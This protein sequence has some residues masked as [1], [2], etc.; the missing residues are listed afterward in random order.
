MPKQIWYT[1]QNIVQAFVD[2]LKRNGWKVATPIAKS[3]RHHGPDVVA[4]RS[5]EKLVAE[6]KGFPLTTY[7]YGPK[8][9]MAKK[10]KPATQARHWYSGA[11][12]EG[13]VRQ[14]EDS[15]ASVCLVFPKHKQYLG[16]Y[17][18]TKVAFLKLGLKVYF[19]DQFGNVQIA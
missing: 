7:Q 3:I 15:S 5:G 11:I 9:G 14:S 16:Y 10:T 13:I 17:E 18:K 4:E 19:V 6:A 8:A 12:L 2:W 1:E